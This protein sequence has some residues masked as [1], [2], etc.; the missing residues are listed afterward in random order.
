MGWFTYEYD[1]KVRLLVQCKL[2]VSFIFLMP[3]GN[4]K[5][6][7]SSVPSAKKRKGGAKKTIQKLRKGGKDKDG[8]IDFEIEK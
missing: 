2:I 3:Q 1:L 7:V 5:A 6:K 8:C 4:H